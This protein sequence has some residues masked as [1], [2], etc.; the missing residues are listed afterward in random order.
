M[1]MMILQVHPRPCHQRVL[2]QHQGHMRFFHPQREVGKSPHLA[3]EPVSRHQ[4]VQCRMSSAPHFHHRHSQ[5]HFPRPLIRHECGIPPLKDCA[6]LLVLHQG[7]LQ[8]VAV[9]AIHFFLHYGLLEARWPA[10]RSRQTIPSSMIWD[11]HKTMHMMICPTRCQQKE[12]MVMAGP[13]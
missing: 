4:P 10:L 7:V 13:D 3:Q 2:V 9:V 5:T 6:N 1:T 12:V 8:V 11:P